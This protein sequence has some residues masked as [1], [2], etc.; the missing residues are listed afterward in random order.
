MRLARIVI[1]IVLIL[2]GSVWALQGAN[3]FAGSVMSGHSQW[4]YI[5][6]ALA[7][8]GV[9]VLLWPNFRRRKP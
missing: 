4:L 6:I 7:V 1:G 9:I 8:I 2:A 5:G 3:V